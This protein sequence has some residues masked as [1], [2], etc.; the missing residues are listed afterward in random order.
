MSNLPSHSKDTRGS[1]YLRVFNPKI[2]LRRRFLAFVIFSIL[3]ILLIYRNDNSSFGSSPSE[4]PVAKEVEKTGENSYPL[5]TE[6]KLVNP[7]D[8]LYE[9]AEH[10]ALTLER[11]KRIKS[12]ML[13]T[14]T[15]YFKNTFGQDEINPSTK[16][17]RQSHNGWGV[18][19]VDS[20]DTLLV[21]SSQ[22]DYIQAKQ[23]IKNMTFPDSSELSLFE[24]TRRYAGGL[25]GAYDLM[26]DA[27]MIEKVNELGKILVQ[28]FDSPSGIPYT[29]INLMSRKATPTNSTEGSLLG[30]IGGIQIEFKRLAQ[31]TGNRNFLEQ[32][33]NVISLIRQQPTRIPGLYPQSIDPSTGEFQSQVVSLEKRGHLFYDTLLKQFLFSLNMMD[34]YRDMYEQSMDSLHEHLIYRD[35]QGRTFLSSLDEDGS[36]MH[37]MNHEA[38]AVPG[39]LALGAHTLKRTKD[40]QVAQELMQT[41][42]DMADATTTGLPPSRIRWAPEHPS[43][44]LTLEQRSQL[45]TLGFYLTEK[46]YQLWPE[47]TESLFLLYRVTSDRK[48][49]EAG[50]KFYLALQKYCKAKYGFSG[51]TD[52]NDELSKDNRMESQFL[53]KTMKYLYLL[54]TPNDFLPIDEYLFTSGGHIIR[55]PRT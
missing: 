23:H 50:W 7:A 54:F 48:Y 3:C 49:Q 46:E 29:T 45:H 8:K 52:T 30:E 41:C 5:S 19:V 47:M 31:V 33:K 20:L 24:T 35:A 44:T 9:S 16:E 34:Q 37:T 4:N 32:S 6:S 43:D 22:Y 12:D 28:A 13:S 36:Q 27:I 10:K 38:C 25:L 39:M 2:L 17:G 15:V 40:L 1:P 14:W 18:T 26:Q 21:L 55:I 53:A 42:I 11:Q 51:L